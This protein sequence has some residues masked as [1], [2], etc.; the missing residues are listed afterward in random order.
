MCITAYEVKSVNN[1]YRLRLDECCY[2]NLISIPYFRSYIFSLLCSI[3]LITTS[4]CLHCIASRYLQQGI[5]CFES[6]SVAPSLSE[7]QLHLRIFFLL[8][9]A[10]RFCSL[11]FFYDPLMC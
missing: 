1:M 9:I 8:R 3:L 10:D 7:M 2:R 6:S 5:R 11:V 4:N